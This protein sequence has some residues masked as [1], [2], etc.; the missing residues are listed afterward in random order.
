MLISISHYQYPKVSY[1]IYQQ[2]KLYHQFWYSTPQRS[3]LENTCDMMHHYQATMHLAMMKM[4]YCLNFQLLYY[5]DLQH[6]EQI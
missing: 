1:R 6:S 3:P 2:S 4:K 5:I